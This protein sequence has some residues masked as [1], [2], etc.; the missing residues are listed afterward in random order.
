M[1]LDCHE[2][3]CLTGV[4]IAHSISN[5][6]STAFVRPVFLQYP[7]AIQLQAYAVELNSRMPIDVALNFLLVMPVFGSRIKLEDL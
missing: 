2:S 5:S 6:T 4:F 7:S 1:A 3:K